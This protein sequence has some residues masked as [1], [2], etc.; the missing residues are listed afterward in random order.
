MFLL[1]SILSF[2]Y[3]DII[4]GPIIGKVNTNSARILIESD[5]ST[6]ITMVLFSNYTKFIMTKKL[7]INNP[8]IFEF[9][10]LEPYTKY[11]IFLPEF[12]NIIPKGSFRTLLGNLTKPFNVIFLSC[13]DR[14]YYSKDNLWL[15]I[16]KQIEKSEV[17]YIFHNGDQVN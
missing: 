14:K 7:F 15:K 10:N 8:T 1:L 16:L 13:N 6:D 12:S 3:A 5:F 2:S 11:Y 9:N 17:D 4:T